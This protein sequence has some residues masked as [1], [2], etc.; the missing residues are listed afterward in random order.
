MSRHNSLIFELKVQD[1]NLRLRFFGPDHED[2]LPVYAEVSAVPFWGTYG[3]EMLSSELKGLL[4]GFR[5]LE[6]SVGKEC[7]IVW[8]NY[9]GNI[10]LKLSLNSR[11]QIVGNYRLAAGPGWEGANLT[12]QFRADQSY[13]C[14]WIQ[15]LERV[16]RELG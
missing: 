13:L 9:E 5:E 6:G 11:G 8:E 7:E 12:G 4:E 1:F 10:Q 16:Q 2:W 14:N 15:Q 3:F